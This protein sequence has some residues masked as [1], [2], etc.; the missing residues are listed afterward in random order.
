[1]VMIVMVWRWWCWRWWWWW[2]GGDG[3]DN[4]NGD[5]GGGVDDDDAG[6]VISPGSS[7]IITPEDFLVSLK[8]LTEWVHCRA[9]LPPREYTT[10]LCCC[11]FTCYAALWTV[12]CKA[13]TFY[14]AFAE[15]R[16]SLKMQMV[17]VTSWEGLHEVLP[18]VIA[19][20]SRMFSCVLSLPQWRCYH[21][22]EPLISHTNV[23][24]GCGRS[25]RTFLE[26]FWL[27]WFSPLCTYWGQ[28]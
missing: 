1:M 11:C 25:W 8:N 9:C 18:I 16:P 4:D 2:C 10:S 12:V 3:G 5:D 15:G 20:E 14:L 6:Y 28:V 24:A 13:L 17:L 19:T 21:N 27:R 22:F 7:H 23:H 26:R